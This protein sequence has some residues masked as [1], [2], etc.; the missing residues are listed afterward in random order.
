MLWQNPTAKATFTGEAAI[1][2]RTYFG[3]DIKLRHLRLIVAIEDAGQ[4]SKA[5]T[6]LHLSQPA[7]SKALSE[8]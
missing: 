4:L 3:R 1:S 7:L 6:V 5:A 2:L 8:I